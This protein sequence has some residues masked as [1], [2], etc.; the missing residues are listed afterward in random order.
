MKKIL[1]FF[2]LA[3]VSQFG[4]AQKISIR[5]QLMD[6]LSSPLPYATV[7]ILNAKDSSLVNFGVTGANGFF[8]IK[9]V[10]RSEYL[11]KISF[12]GFAPFTQRI[13]PPAGT[14]EFNLGQ[15]HLQPQSKILNEVTI[16]GEK[17]PVTVKKDTIEFNA[18]SFKVKVN[19]TAEDLIKKLPGMEVDNDG[20]I[21]AQGEQVQRV[22]VEGKE[23]FGQDPKL[24]TR[25]LPADA[26]EKVQVYDKK[27]DQAVF[28]GVEDGQRE[29]TINLALKEDKKH[30]A[31]GNDMA[32][33]GTGN[34]FQAKASINRFNKGN[35]LSFLGMGN[36]I[37]EQGFSAGDFANFSGNQGGGGGGGGGAVVI[38]AGGNNQS[39]AQINTG[40]QNGIVTNFAGGLNL[41]HGFN[42]DKTKISGSY[43][44]NRLDQNLST[45]THR[46]NYLPNGSYDFD[47]NSLQHTVNDNH[48]VNLT[49]D[50]K[51]DS[52]NSIKSNISVAYSLSDQTLNSRGLT[53]NVGN[54]TP[55]NS[56]D[57]KTTSTG[58]SITLNSNLL[59]RHRFKKKGRTISTNFT[60][61]YN[62]SI[63][64]GSLQSRNIFY[65]NLGDKQDSVDVM[66]INTQTTTS[67]TYGV[68]TSFTEPL[69]NR[70]Y[71]EFNYNFSADINHVDRPVYDVKSDIKTFNDSLSNKYQSNY[72]YNRPGV[73]FRINRDQFN[74]T[75]GTAWQQTQLNGN[76]ILKNTRIDRSFQAVLPIIHFNY[77]Y[78]NFKHLRIDYTT[79]MQAPTIQQLQPI[80][81][82]SDQL[83]QSTGNPLLKPAYVQQLRSNFT[84][85]DPARFMNFFAFINGN[86]TTNAIVNSQTTTARL[87]R[88]TKPVN[89]RNS[90]SLSGNI[91]LGI[92]VKALN[93][94]FNFGPSYSISSSINLTNE[95]ENIVR[96][97]TLGGTAR[98]NYS[99]KEILIVDLSANLSHQ[100]TKYSFNTQQNQVYFNKTYT[101]EVNINFLKNYAFNT[102]MNYFV[103]NSTTTNFHQTIPLWSMS[104]SRFLLHN[105]KG[106]LKLS[107]SN[108]LDQSLS[109]TQTASTNYLQQQTMNNL[110]R[111]YMVTFTYALN[112]QLNPMND[113]RG[114]GGMRMMIRQ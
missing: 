108:L 104:L 62:Q 111:F 8:E 97:Q 99:L 75:I 55:K 64:N 76:L 82:N 3:I 12:M 9:N 21:R 39:G 51:I 54:Q 15:I 114:G 61:A 37:N 17:A 100:E 25:N 52:A 109:V 36:N 66:Q 68:N 35:Q 19:G 113:R 22:M 86:Y 6:S 98:Y 47:Q 33:A 59:F 4:M 30:A 34:H 83:N 7:M 40:R 70:R 74:L 56:N 67:P 57:Q 27:S 49:I 38:Q 60:F 41:N 45:V 5:G 102:E 101:A 63:S 88:I 10:A 95:V 50:Q 31:F 90:M 112:K 32:G 103:Y 58:N 69:G 2:S 1:L 78:S 96:Q 106:E 77:D 23:F 92:P 85:F 24:A 53:Q 16:Q 79:S 110:G 43:F 18:G 42:S 87:V 20:T 89:V 48:R 93:S 28:S 13:F 46:I 72:L 84:Y 14:L 105:K 29:K 81:N 11:F 94:R 80:V 44:Y 65:T 73:N 71:L 107:V 91:N 26:V